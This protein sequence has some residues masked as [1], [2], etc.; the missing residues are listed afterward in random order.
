MSIENADIPDTWSSNRGYIDR[1]QTDEQIDQI[2]TL[3]DLDSAHGLVDVGCSNGAFAIAAAERYPHCQVWAL[4]PLES[5]VAECRR[6]AATRKIGNLR[7]EVASADALPLESSSA[8]RALMRNVL[9]HLARPDRAYAEL[10]RVLAPNGLLLLEAPSNPGDTQLG[11]LISDVHMFMDDS[12]RRTYHRPEAIT[13]GLAAH[14][15]GAEVTDSW[16]YS[17]R[18][19]PEQVR[20]IQQHGAEEALSLR[21]ESA[22]RWVIQL[23]MVRVVGRKRGSP[24]PSAPGAGGQG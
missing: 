2:L 10:A 4:D 19:R 24:P 17:P 1:F 16:A 15:I 13:S 11:R 6:S 7:T 21:Q 12:H 20:L 5:A 22:D 8:D 18:M 23:N 14:G 9:H 3:P